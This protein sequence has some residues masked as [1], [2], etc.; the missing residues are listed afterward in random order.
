[1][2]LLSVGVVAVVLAACGG[3]KPETAVAPQPNADSIAAAEKARQEALAAAEAER[4]AREEAERLARQRTADSLAALGQSSEAVRTLLARQIIS[5]WTSP[6]FVATKSA[7]SIRK[8]RSSRPTRVPGSAYP[9][10][11]TSAGPMSTIWRWATAGRLPP[12]S[13]S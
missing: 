7:C 1:M 3:K 12:S 10:I 11:A 4:L 13:T 8:Y 2:L 6:S 5:T 9:V